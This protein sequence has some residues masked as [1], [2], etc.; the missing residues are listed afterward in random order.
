MNN[1]PLSCGPDAAIN[2]VWLRK[3]RPRSAGAWNDLRMRKQLILSE[4]R[5]RSPAWA[6]LLGIVGLALGLAPVRG[7]STYQLVIPTYS[8]YESGT[9]VTVAVIRT[10]DLSLPGSVTFGTADGTANV[11]A[12]YT[13]TNGVLDFAANELVKTFDVFITQDA[14]AEPDETVMLTQ[15]GRAHV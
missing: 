12:D 2:R 4:T 8:V 1:G 6:V 9:N 15:I 3:Q 10:G 14:V 7:Q 11:L 5:R 13:A